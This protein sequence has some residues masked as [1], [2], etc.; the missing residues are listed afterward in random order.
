[1]RRAAA[2]DAVDDTVINPLVVQINGLFYY[3]IP[4]SSLLANDTGVTTKSFSIVGGDTA[5]CFESGSYVYVSTSQ[6]TGFQYVGSNTTDIATVSVVVNSGGNTMLQGLEDSFEFPQFL[7]AGSEF[8]TLANWTSNGAQ[9]A[10][11]V[12]SSAFGGVT[13]SDGQ[14]FIALDSTSAQDSIKTTGLDLADG[15]AYTL[16]LDASGVARSVTDAF[17]VFY[18]G[19]LL[20]TVDP[21][22]GWS[23]TTFTFNADVAPV[24][25]DAIEFR[26]VG[27]PGVGDMN[28]AYIDH[29][30]FLLV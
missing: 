30:S 11:K 2:Y 15:K 19:K 10:L 20:G 24:N 25:G 21:K 3:Q 22:G 17:D 27:G 9:G 23:T 13:A 6:T 1:M 12:L 5:T 8:A 7:S 16:S 28:G 29:V 26:E 4:I 18:N 14:Y